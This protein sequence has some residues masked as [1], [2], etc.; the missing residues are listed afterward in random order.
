MPHSFGYRAATRTLFK[1][2][3]K[4]NGRCHTTTYLR[5]FKRGDYVDIKVDSSIHKGMPFKHYH[6]RTGVVFNVNKRAVGVIVNKE[7]NGR[8]LRKQLHI[9]TPHLLP[10]TC[11]SQIIARKKANDAHKAA[12]KAGK[13]E[14]K[15][16]KRVNT[17]PKAS[18]FYQLEATPETIQPL[19]YVDLV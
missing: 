3:F 10:S 4:T 9:S 8:I 5:N 6:G 18:Y 17:Q 15:N 1:K 11:Q 2:A 13:A 16:L 7:V 14:K 12:V 19:P